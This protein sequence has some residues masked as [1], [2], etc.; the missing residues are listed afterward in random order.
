MQNIQRGAQERITLNVYSNGELTQADV[1]PTVTVYDADK[2]STP[3]TGYNVIPATNDPDAGVYSYLITPALTQ[4]NRVLEIKWNYLIGGIATY[5]T[6]F[7]SIETTYSTVS[8]IIDAYS[9]GTQSSDV[10]Y[11]SINDIL[12]AEKIARI[13]IDNYTNQTFGTYYGLQEITAIGSDAIEL[14]EKILTVDRLYEDGILVIDYTLTPV[15]NNFGYNVEI[16]PT[17][18]AV[19]IINNS[20]DVRYSNQTDLIVMY[21]GKF[22]DNTRYLVQGQMGWKYVPE[23]IKTASIMLIG[24]I[25]SNDFNWRNKYLVKV[26][27]SE[28]SFEMDKAAFTGTG[29]IVVDDILNGYTRLNIVI[30]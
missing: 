7:Y 24:D 3:L 5:Q 8:E 19:R 22:R 18:F 6:E 28:I 29:N 13:V 12:R 2:D 27:L 9:F 26:D 25:L 21:Y 30:I 10:N 20:S 23:D 4:L 11:K 14:N 1:L 17:G 15:L 16:T